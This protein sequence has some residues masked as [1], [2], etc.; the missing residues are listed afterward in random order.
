MY[1][2]ERHRFW[3]G[4]SFLPFPKLATVLSVVVVVAREGVLHFLRRVLHHVAEVL[5]VVVLIVLLVLFCHGSDLP[6]SVCVAGR[7]PSHHYFAP[8]TV[9]PFF[10]AFGCFP[11]TSLRIHGN[12][13]IIYRVLPKAS[14]DC[15]PLRRQSPFFV[16]GVIFRMGV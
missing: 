16:F 11:S 2:R 9:R 14:G 4:R 7:L 6:L 15:T 3:P 13:G 10:F 8:G 5:I 12:L 1:G